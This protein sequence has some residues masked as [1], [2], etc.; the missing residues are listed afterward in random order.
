[1]VLP[2]DSTVKVIDQLVDR[3]VGTNFFTSRGTL[4]PVD[5]R[6]TLAK[7]KQHNYIKPQ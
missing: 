3:L 7:L 6:D 5:Q 2:L 1:M 4:E